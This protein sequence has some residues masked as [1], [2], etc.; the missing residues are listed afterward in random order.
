MTNDKQHTE[1]P[2]IE[3][4]A[5]AITDIGFSKLLAGESA[6]EV[7]AYGAIAQWLAVL[8]QAIADEEWTIVKELADGSLSSDDAA[9]YFGW[10]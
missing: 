9:H 7:R 10:L 2:N 6:E 1:N 8:G 5:H 4:I 3:G